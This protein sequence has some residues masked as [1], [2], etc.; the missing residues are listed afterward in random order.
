MPTG[1]QLFNPG[2]KC[3]KQLYYDHFIYSFPEEVFYNK[4]DEMEEALGVPLLGFLRDELFL[5]GILEENDRGDSRIGPKMRKRMKEYLLIHPMP[6]PP[7]TG[8]KSAMK[9]RQEKGLKQL[10]MTGREMRF[11]IL[12]HTSEGAIIWNRDIGVIVVAG[13]SWCYVYKTG[14]SFVMD[15]NFHILGYFQLG[16]ND[17]PGQLNKAINGEMQPRA[18][19]L[20]LRRRAY[21]I[22]KK[23]GQD[24]PRISI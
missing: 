23:K 18:D 20:S 4:A 17:I 15:V 10:V 3:L 2:P 13:R 19:A 7:Q 9:I 21:M 5:F 16:G 8:K 1:K 22:R 11:D 14:H 24:R 6:L 12:A